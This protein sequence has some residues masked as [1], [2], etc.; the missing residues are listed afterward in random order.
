MDFHSQSVAA[1]LKINDKHDILF[2][3]SSI[4]WVVKCRNCV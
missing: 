3:T 2:F 4:G 1:C